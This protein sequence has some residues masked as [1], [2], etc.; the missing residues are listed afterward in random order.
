[1]V[2]AVIGM[3]I[4][5]ISAKFVF[6]RN[7]KISNYDCMAFYG[8]CLT[9]TYFVW[10]RISGV[11]L[12]LNQLPAKPMVAMVVSLI[13]TVL[14][15][16]LVLKGISMISVG[17]SILIYSTNPIFGMLL[18]ALILS[19]RTSQLVLVFTLGAFSGIY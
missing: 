17:K 1:M 2:V 15:S 4:S 16:L 9:L 19:E 13:S 6:S 3:S 7:P 18:A 14:C 10:S 8:V 5:H 11:S 12:L